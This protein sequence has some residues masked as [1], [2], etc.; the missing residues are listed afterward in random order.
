MNNKPTRL[1]LLIYAITVFLLTSCGDNDISL[2]GRMLNGLLWREI[3][4][5]TYGGRISAI[6]VAP[7][8]TKTLFVS[9]STGGIYRSGD[10]GQNWVPVFDGAG[11]SLAIGDI[12][13][14]ES[15]P[16]LIWVGSGEASGE[17]SPA[18]IGDGVYKSTDGGDSWTNMGLNGTRH[19][20]RIV[21]HPE[22]ND[23]VFAG[24]TGSR[25]GENEERGVFR[26]T[27]GG[28]SWE[29]VLYINENTGISD[30]VIMPG[31]K[32]LYA[33]AWEQRRNAWAHVRT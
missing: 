26:T 12:D 33:S 14:S 11:R 16:M 8:E 2:N 22:N 23:I 24:A 7:G 3:G 9:P 25:W 6:A 1:L 30:I 28:V 31:G 15:D 29:R 10:E 20:S 32:T 13:I 4:P 19:I 21:I 5:G 17:Q 27:D 18:S